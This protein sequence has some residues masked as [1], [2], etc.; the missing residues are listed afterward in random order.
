MPARKS[1]S[2]WTTNRI[3]ARIHALKQKGED[4]SYNRMAHAAGGLISAASYHFGSWKKAVEAAGF[5]YDHEVRRI[6]RW[7]KEKIIEAIQSAG[8]RGVD[9]SW[10]NVT[11]KPE[12]SAIAYAAIRNPRFGSWD[13][14]LRAAGIDPAQVRRYET[15]NKDRVIR[16]I[17]DRAKA[18]EGLNS[19]TMQEQ[20]CKLFNAALK[21]FG[22]WGSALKAAGINPA[23]VYKRRRWDQAIVKKEIKALL[24]SKTDLAA[25]FVRQHHQA[26]YSASCK[27]F[28]SWTAARRASGVRKSFRKRKR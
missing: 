18:G 6:P 16:G 27:Y 23:R 15:W 12:Y 17:K 24:R 14:T 11:K 4:L 5:D 7:S 21:R 26:L 9:L 1:P 25:S 19:K 22:N 8:A 10:T 28:G 20:A 13:K 2:R 3:I